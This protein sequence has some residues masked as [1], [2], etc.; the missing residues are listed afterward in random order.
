MRRARTTPDAGSDEPL[1]TFLVPDPDGR[2]RI[3]LCGLTREVDVDIAIELGVDAVGLVF[4]PPSARHLTIDAA[5]RLAARLP[6][7]ITATGLFVDAT[8]ATIESAIDA[9]P[10]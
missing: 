5:A 7:S 10:L 1:M 2:T 9:V 8:R 6:S 3:K 4:Y